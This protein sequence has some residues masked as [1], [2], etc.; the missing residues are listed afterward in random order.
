MADTRH[1]DVRSSFTSDERSVL[2]ALTVAALLNGI[3]EFLRDKDPCL[4]EDVLD[5]LARVHS[6]CMKLTDEIRAKQS[7]TQ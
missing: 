3:T 2:L 6:K 7:T 4:F 5:D 1:G